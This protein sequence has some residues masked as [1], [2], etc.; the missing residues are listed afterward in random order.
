MKDPKDCAHEDFAT[1][2]RVG[3]MLDT[4][5]FIAEIHIHCTQCHEPFRFL[6]VSAGPRMGP[7]HD[8]DR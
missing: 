4:G 7:S 1:E 2:V 3:R 6:G 8:V 5:K